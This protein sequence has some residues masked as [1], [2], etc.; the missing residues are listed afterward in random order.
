LKDLKLKDN[1]KLNSL[2]KKGLN[3]EIALSMKNL[4]VLRMKK[5]KGEL[6][7]T[8]II[9]FLRRYIA[10]VKTIANIKVD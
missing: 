9:K 1:S 10:K 4:F 6:K 2:D 5:E 3:E 7:N 8:H